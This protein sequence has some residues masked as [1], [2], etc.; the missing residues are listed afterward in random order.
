[1]S[2]LTRR[3]F[4][5]GAA[6]TAV[7][8]RCSTAPHTITVDDVSR[9]DRPNIVLLM[10]DDLGYGD[11]GFNGNEVL[12]TP[13][14]DRLREEGLRF[15]RFYA[16]SP[17]CSPTRG[18]CL[19]GRHY[20]RY[21]ITHANRGCL[22]RQEVTLAEICKRAGY[23]TGHFGKWHLGTLTKT[24]KDGNRGGPDHPEFYAPPWDR[25]FDV[26]FSTEALVPTWDPAVTPQEGN[27]VWGTPG[28]PWKCAYWN[29]RGERVTENLDGDDSR[30][31][32]DRVV[33]YI[34]SAV[35]DHRPFFAVVWFHTPHAPVVAGP[36]YR[37]IYARYS[38]A[39][40]H[41]FGC[42][43]AM[44]EQVGRLSALLKEL[45]IEQ[46][47]MVWFCSDNGP[48]G[49]GAPDDGTRFRGSTGGFRGRKRSLFNGGIAVP[50]LLKWPRLVRAAS[51]CS[52]PCST[53]DYL[54]TIADVLEVALPDDRPIDGISLMPL[55]R[56]GETERPRP[57]PFF[58][59]DSKPLM[60]DAPTLAMLDN[61]YKVLTNLSAT[62]D[63][64]LCYDLL[65]D[66]FEERNIAPY[67]REYISEK[68]RELR[69]FIESCRRS[70]QGAD[71]PE[72]YTPITDFPDVTGDW[73]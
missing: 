54:P 66:P 72:P 34:R 44:D 24:H 73:G 45:H 38:E 68:R 51:T 3:S 67:M 49:K 69:A 31:I 71:Y 29:E 58:F 1:M 37:A 28:T 46:D 70:H 60:F 33:P 32:M 19:T 55:L 14:L 30:V 25:G 15:T 64:D 9:P 10:C 11:T 56:G 57:I 18:T 59:R 41:Y 4:L 5:A 50:G 16:G 22:P 65:E 20:A 12:R 27:N 23:I 8:V 13:S 21:G 52:A 6:A 62:G 47:T 53:L 36:D 61:R 17:V 39:E 43:T 2:S 40:Q 7:S 35:A 42:V 26:C 48:E 63:E